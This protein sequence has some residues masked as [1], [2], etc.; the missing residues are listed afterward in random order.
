MR[1]FIGCV[2]A[3]KRVSYAVTVD[4]MILLYTGLMHFSNA[5]L[6]VIRHSWKKRLSALRSGIKA[7]S[8]EDND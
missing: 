3:V 7:L 4:L 2:T 1:L 8:T 5:R 6:N